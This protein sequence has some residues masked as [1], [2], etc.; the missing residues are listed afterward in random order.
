MR[1]GG[2]PARRVEVDRNVRGKGDDRGR[3]K[4]NSGFDTRGLRA[5]LGR[6][7]ESKQRDRSRGGELGTADANY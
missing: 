4:I 5:D 6:C 3:K 1:L 2:L 7:C